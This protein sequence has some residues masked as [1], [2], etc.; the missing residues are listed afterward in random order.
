LQK[1]IQDSDSLLSATT[2]AKTNLNNILYPFV[3]FNKTRNEFTITS[4]DFSTSGTY[5]LIM[6]ATL[7]ETYYN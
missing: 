2:F 6:K 5:T 7:L 4:S 1:T 3:T